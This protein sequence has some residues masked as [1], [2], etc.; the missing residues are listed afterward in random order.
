MTA[1]LELSGAY[2][3]SMIALLVG[4]GAVFLIVWLC[5]RGGR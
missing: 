3:L 1:L 5:G 4:V 2:W